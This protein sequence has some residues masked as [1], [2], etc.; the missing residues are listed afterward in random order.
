[1]GNTDEKLEILLLLY[2]STKKTNQ[3]KKHKRMKEKERKEKEL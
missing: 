3:T 1:M 2:P